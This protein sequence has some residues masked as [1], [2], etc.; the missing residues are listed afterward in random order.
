MNGGQKFHKY[1]CTRPYFKYIH[2]NVND[3]KEKVKIIYLVSKIIIWSIEKVS[4]KM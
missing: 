3:N 1:L 2:D 4:I